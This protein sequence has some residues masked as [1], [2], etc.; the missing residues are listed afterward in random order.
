MPTIWRDFRLQE[1]SDEEAAAERSARRPPPPIE[2]ALVRWRGGRRERKAAA[3]AERERHLEEVRARRALRTKMSCLECAG[4]A[5]CADCRRF[6]SYAERDRRRGLEMALSREAFG[7][8]LHGACA[9]CGVEEAG[10]LD[11]VDPREGYRPGN[12]VS[13][14]RVCNRA[15]HTFLPSEWEAYLVRLV[16]FRTRP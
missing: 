11:R 13:C 5:R 2:G 3:R 4:R 14:C 9:Y 1:V 8:L 12:V 6:V 16:A 10:T 15:K 7:V